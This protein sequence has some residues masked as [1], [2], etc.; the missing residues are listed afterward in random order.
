MLFKVADMLYNTC[1][2]RDPEAG[3]QP[4]ICQ[5]SPI[6]AMFWPTPAPKFGQSVADV[7]QMLGQVW[8]DLLRTTSDLRLT[9]QDVQLAN[10]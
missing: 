3:V 6:Q 5:F 8:S 2:T 10:S 4:D 7:V 9:I 1:S